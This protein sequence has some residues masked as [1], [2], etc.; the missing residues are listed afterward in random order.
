MEEVRNVSDFLLCRFD[1]SW[2]RVEFERKEMVA[3][4]NVGRLSVTLRRRGNLQQ[5]AYVSIQVREI[6]AKI[7]EDFIP[8]SAKQVQFDPGQ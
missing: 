6:S 3:C 2:S 1:M 5:S 7:G 4:E 8:S